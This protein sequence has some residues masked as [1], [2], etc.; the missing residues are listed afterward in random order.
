MLTFT[1]RQS[2]GSV[3]LLGDIA[4]VY[5]TAMLGRE[6]GQ[7]QRCFL[8]RAG[9]RKEFRNDAGEL[10]LILISGT[11]WQA[12]FEC[13]FD[14][15]VTAPGFMEEITLPLL[16]I[17]GRVMEGARVTWEGD[18][19]R[20]ITIPCAEWDSM[21]GV[22]TAYR[23]TPAGEAVDIPTPETEPGTFGGLLGGVPLEVPA[24]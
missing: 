22:A 16:G 4:P 3:Y 12:E 5:G 7:I 14:A 17:T 23:L 1:D 6:F 2:T 13:L 24:A 9:E 11:G 8:V 18:A 20:V 10:L 21:E 19:E 15:S